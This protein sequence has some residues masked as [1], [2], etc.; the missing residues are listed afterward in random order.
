MTKTRERRNRNNELKKA[1]YIV[2]RLRLV[3]YSLCKSI[4]CSLCSIKNNML[5]S[6]FYWTRER[7]RET[8]REREQHQNGTRVDETVAGDCF[9]LARRRLL[10]R[11]VRLSRGTRFRV[12]EVSPTKR[13]LTTFRKRKGNEGGDDENDEE[14]FSRRWRW[15][16]CWWWWKQPFG[17]EAF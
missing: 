16:W 9:P 13:T 17:N 14:T 10:V 8:E 1:V 11:S 5:R 3:S 12:Y 7:A 6:P 2:S 4:N 15:R